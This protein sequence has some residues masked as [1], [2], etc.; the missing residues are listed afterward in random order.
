VARALLMVLILIGLLVTGG[1]SSANARSGNREPPPPISDGPTGAAVLRPAFFSIDLPRSY[2]WRQAASSPT[3][4]VFWVRVSP[5]LTMVATVIWYFLEPNA[6]FI[7]NGDN[8]LDAVI[9][10]RFAVHK[11]V[12]QAV[13]TAALIPAEKR[14]LSDGLCQGYTST[15]IDRLESSNGGAAY[16]V[17][18]DGM[19]CLHPAGKG[20]V[21]L[22]FSERYGQSMTTHMEF[23]KTGD[24]FFTS[25]R[26]VEY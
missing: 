8:V 10:A 19:A 14:N 20:I 25:F 18:L 12:G 23:N 22:E 9:G 21:L 6:D 1:V 7:A 4:S 13:K 17:R 3:N 26:F 5:S 24:D 11:A 2:N 16:S 15:I